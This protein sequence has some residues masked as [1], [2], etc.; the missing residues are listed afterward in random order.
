[1]RPMPLHQRFTPAP[2]ALAAVMAIALAAGHAPLAHAQSGASATAATPITINIPAQPLGQALNELARQANLQLSFPPALVADKTAP[3]VS[4]N[5]TTRQALDRLLAG[6][7]LVA[8]AEGSSVVIR[9]APSQQGGEAVLPVVTVTELGAKPL[10]G[11]LPSPY[12]GAQVA[13]G[14]RVGILGNLDIFS[15]PFS[16][17]AYTDELL[18]NQQARAISDVVINDPSI[19]LGLPRY[20][21]QDQFVIRGFRT[22]QQDILF[23]GIG[24]V[25]DQRRPAIDNVERVEILKG[26]SALLYNTTVNGVFSGIINYAPKRAPDE[27]LNRV[28]VSFVSREEIGASA[29]LARRFGP[30]N[31]WGVR[32]NGTLRDGNGPIRGSETGYRFGSLGLDFRGERL[33][34][35]LDAGY[36]VQNHDSFQALATVGPLVTVMPHVP[37]SDLNQN[38]PWTLEHTQL[39][40]AA[41]RTEF[42]ATDS[43][44]VYAAA[45]GSQWESDRFIV[46][47]TITSNAGD[48]TGAVFNDLFDTISYGYDVG[49]KAKLRTGLINHRVAVSAAGNTRTGDYLDTGIVAPG[50]ATNIYNPVFPAA[51]LR[52]EFS[53][54]QYAPSFTNIN[55]SVAISD[56]LTAYA[57]RVVVAIGGRLQSVKTKNYQQTFGAADFGRETFNFSDQAF[58]PAVG[59]VVK[60]LKKLSLYGNY[61]EGLQAGSVA[62]ATAANA[63]QGTPPF[64]NTQFEIGAKYDFGSFGVTAAYFEIERQSAFTDPATNI[65]AANGRQLN[66]GVELNVFGEPAAGLRLL[67]GVAFIDASLTETV[68]GTLNGRTPSGVPDYQGVIYAEYDLPPNLARGLTLT[69]RVLHSGSQHV[70]Q[71]NTLEIPN[72]TRFDAGLRYAFKGYGGKPVVLRAEVE[73][74]QGKDYWQTAID[75]LLSQSAPRTFK[76]SASFDF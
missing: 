15:T 64:K 52:R 72:W 66:K 8:S 46:G 74:I 1:M 14:A 7:G 23:D 59:V 54:S 69:G 31:Q 12:A 32:L 70:N 73:N 40:F 56:V 61:V 36:Q 60:P 75:G 57:E 4:G 34:S 5:L 45:G 50:L 62:P 43:L 67:G 3:A 28:S 51:P 2:P 11:E 37:K 63:G 49:L 68:G 38:P 48:R 42:D 19:Q 30:D 55:N 24:G 26:P 65:F 58:S 25:V 9:P 39:K 6:S 17:T 53:R 41:A 10:P 44:T 21:L 29:D 18:R 27:D 76:L 35:S 20:G 22:F 71:T 33:R 13:K 47:Y 16:I